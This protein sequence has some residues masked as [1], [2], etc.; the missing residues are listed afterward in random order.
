M[1]NLLDKKRYDVAAKIMKKLHISIDKYPDVQI[2]LIENGARSMHKWEK[3]K[4][5]WEM[6]EEVY[7]RFPIAIAASIKSLMFGKVN[8]KMV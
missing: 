4:F 5:S 1:K 3:E 8:A 7:G 6:L 2:K